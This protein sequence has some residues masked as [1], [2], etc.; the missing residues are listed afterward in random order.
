MHVMHV[1]QDYKGV[2][3][4][5]RKAVEEVSQDA[6]ARYLKGETIVIPT[7]MRIKD[8]DSEKQKEKKQRALKSLKKRI[9]CD[10]AVH[11]PS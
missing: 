4:P 11:I 5:T 6:Y 2:N 3:A 8:T 9:R 1:M 10:L 7:W